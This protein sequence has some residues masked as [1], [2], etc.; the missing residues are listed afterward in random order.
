MSDNRQIVDGLFK[1]IDSKD[2]ESFVSYL[3]DDAVFSMGDAPS[4]SGKENINVAVDQF[5]QSIKG[6]SHRVDNVI[7]SGNDLVTP[8]IVTYTRHDGS[9]LTVNFCNVYGLEGGK[10]KKYDVYIDLSAL[11]K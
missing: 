7:E 3:A 11:Y 1:S 9:E 5:F 10:I 6:L 8:G 4:V 2:T